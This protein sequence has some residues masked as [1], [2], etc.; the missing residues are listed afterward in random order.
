MLA[1]ID[2]IVEKLHQYTGKPFSELTETELYAIRYL[3][4]CLV[5]EIISICVHI[6]AEEWEERP[7]TYTQCLKVLREKGGIECVEDLIPMVRLRNL[8]IHRYWEIDDRCVYQSIQQN[9]ECVRAFTTWVRT[10]YEI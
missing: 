3:V 9:F 2:E 10:R 8:L 1:K 7:A 6:I 5:E 4:I